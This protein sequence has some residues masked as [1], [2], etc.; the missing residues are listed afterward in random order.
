MTTTS[1][2][3]KF[4]KDG[5]D[6]FINPIFTGNLLLKLGGVVIN[7]NDTTTIS[8]GCFL[9]ISGSA[10]ISNNLNTKSISISGT[11]ATL[12]SKNIATQD[13]VDASLNTLKTYVDASLNTLKTYVD[14]S[15]NTL[16]TY[17]DASYAL[18]TYV[19]ASYAL[20]T[21]VDTSLNT[22]KT[23]V[24][25]SYAL[26]TYVDTS[27]NTLKTY[28]D[29][30]YALKTYVDTSL[31]T[32]K[33]YVDASYA[34]KTY[35]DT[36]Y[37]LKSYVDASYALKSYVDTTYA[38]GDNPTIRSHTILT[39]YFEY[40]LF[41]NRPNNADYYKKISQDPGIY[42]FI[43]TSLTIDLNS[44]FGG[45]FNDMRFRSYSKNSDGSGFVYTDFTALTSTNTY[46]LAF[47]VNTDNKHSRYNE[48]FTYTNAT[49][50][51]VNNKSQDVGLNIIITGES[52]EG[53][54]TDAIA[55]VKVTYSVLKYMGFT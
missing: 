44:G 17:V 9:D 39:N 51:F 5:L 10:N 23:Y 2:N 52:L 30:S 8:N 32:L 48:S 49:T 3:G 42:K 34:L 38:L 19:D 40:Q 4:L 20:K 27:L 18:K 45:R 29:A 50:I 36:S 28:V 11:T 54:V 16:K 43:V 55:N 25:A 15:L 6:I 35:V 37:A 1:I 12:G 41:C 53:G 7:K 26:K 13:Y 21:Y 24:D 31:N 33:S 47:G 22:L 14:A 46:D